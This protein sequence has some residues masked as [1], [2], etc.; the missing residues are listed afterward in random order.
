MKYILPS[1]ILICL[2]GVAYAAPTLIYQR[3]ILPEAD[4][5]YD[6]GSNA[7]RWANIYGDTIYGDGSNLTGVS[8]SGIENLNSETLGSIGDVSTTTL[9]SQDI[10]TWTG[11][12]WVSS[13]TLSLFDEKWDTLYNATTTLNGHPLVTV[14]GETYVTLSGQELTMAKLDLSETNLTVTSPITLTTNDIS[15]D[16]TTANTWSG[17]N[18]FSSDLRATGGLHASTTDFDIL[19]VNGN[20]TLTGYAS[21]TTGLFTQGDGHIGG[22]FVTD[23]TGSFA[24]ANLTIDISG[25]L[26][27]TGFASSTTG[28]FTQGSGHIGGN[29]T[30]DGT[31][32]DSFSDY[33]ANEHLDWTASV[34]TIH[35]GNY[36]N[37]TYTSSDFTHDDL[38]A[39][40]IADHDTVTTGAE[41]TS[42]ADN[43]IVNTLHRHSELV[44]SDGA[45]DPALTVNASGNVGIGTTSPLHKLSIEGDYFGLGN[46]TTTGSLYIG[47]DLTVVGT[48]S[49]TT[50]LF[51][52][53]ELHIGTN[54]VIEGT[55]TLPALGV[56]AGTFLAVDANGLIIAT[57]TPSGG[58]VTL[59]GQDYL[60]IA[61]Q[62]ITAGEIE[63]DDL[64]AS[65]FGEFTCNGTTCVLEATNTTL[66]T[67][68]NVVEVGALN[69]G[70]ITSG[71]TSIDVGAGAIDGGVITADTNFAG[72]LTGAV[73]GAASGNLL[74]SESDTLIGT[75]TADGLTLGS[76]EILT[77]GTNLFT[78]DGTDFTLDDTLVVTGYA[79]STLGL[80]T[81]GTLHIGGNSTFDGTGHDSFSDYV[82]DEH[83]NWKNS[84]GTIHADNYTNTTY[85][86]GINLTLDGTAFDVDDAFLVNDAAD[87]GVGITLT[88]STTTGTMTIPQG[89][90]PEVT[91]IGQ[92]ALDSSDDQLIVMGATEKVIRTD[93][94]I[95]RFTFA[96][97]SPDFVSGG[98]LPVPPEKDGYTITSYSCYV[99]GGT[100]VVLTPN[101]A[102]QGDLDAITCATTITKDTTMTAASIIAAD[103][104]VKM[105]IGTVTGVPDYV[106]FTAFGKWT[107]E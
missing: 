68:A 19:T 49:S 95:F 48:A 29:L 65:D 73:T 80:N 54:G 27:T 98:E 90:A 63:P 43:S 67:L 8:G 91:V 93:E 30:T 36:T 83:L 35:A 39:G 92:I 85:T 50:G 11:T 76:T 88:Y 17:I 78:H 64:A 87:I 53:G 31:G 89:A 16:Y 6:L 14:T 28:L 99:T 15:F 24:L 46:A 75:L 12:G 59:A 72:D 18:T 38:I 104:L 102:S 7:V 32:H 41:L 2:A 4:S 79:S 107:R 1:L 9:S 5:T 44:A 100:S 106:S 42:L 26:V 61:A 13:S 56:A 97:T 40:T 22:N 23:G 66:T 45:P 86:G 52:Q 94:A 25:N 47:D 77:I 37:T 57:T 33:V 71:F 74:N 58:T 51:T 103:E 70:S 101:G 21:S 20:G 84:V 82:A 96:S 62:E 69:A 34:G 55:L 105:K 10:L 3:T 60:T 81:Q